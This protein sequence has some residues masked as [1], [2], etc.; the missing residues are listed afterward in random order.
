[1]PLAH[2][3]LPDHGHAVGNE[4]GVEGLGTVRLASESP[5]QYLLFTY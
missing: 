4:H 1:M 2:I 3:C 5:P